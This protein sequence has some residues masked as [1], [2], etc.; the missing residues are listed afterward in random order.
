MLITVPAFQSLFSNHDVFLKH[1]RRYGRKQL[2][3]LLRS[4]GLHVEK[5]HYFYSGL[6]FARW[7]SLLLTKEKPVEKQ[8]S[9]GEWRFGEKH[10]ITRIVRAI[11]NIDFR[12]C[13]ALAKLRIYLPGLSLLAVCRK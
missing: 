11:L 5:C 9:I 8:T 10:V 2:L 13:A 7:A 12:V 6:F 3:V 4:C 1:R